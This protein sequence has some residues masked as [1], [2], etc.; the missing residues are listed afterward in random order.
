VYVTGQDSAQPPT[1][2]C[3]TVIVRYKGDPLITLTRLVYNKG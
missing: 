2:L 3:V 1:F